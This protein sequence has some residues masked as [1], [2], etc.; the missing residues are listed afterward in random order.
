MPHR[1]IDRLVRSLALGLALIVGSL[2]RCPQVQAQDGAGLTCP[3]VGSTAVPGLLADPSEASLMLNGTTI[4]LANEINGLIY[5]VQSE[6][7]NISYDELTDVLIA[8]Y[9]PVVAKANGLTDHQK[10]TRMRQF[11]K[12]IEQQVAA[13]S[14]PPG[15]L[16]I[17][18]VPLPPEV[19]RRLQIQARQR[20][21]TPAQYMGGILSQAAT[22]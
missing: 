1:F 13:N 5:R 9:C 10:W 4:D 22:K 3:V 15:S 20:D 16:I 8:A 12:L 14:M 17:A 7:P 18:N 21:Q 6:K 2:P 19:F 11:D